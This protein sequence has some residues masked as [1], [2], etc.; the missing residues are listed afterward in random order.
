MAASAPKPAALQRLKDF[1]KRTFY[2]GRAVVSSPS[3]SDSPVA[4][5]P[6]ATFSALRALPSSMVG[7]TAGGMSDE[8]DPLRGAAIGGA[9]GLGHG[10]LN[11]ALMASA[12]R[13]RAEAAMTGGS[14][15]IPHEVAHM[16]SM[17]S[18][19]AAIGGA[20]GKDNEDRVKRAIAGAG[21]GGG[22]RAGRLL[23]KVLGPNYGM[24]LPLSVATIPLGG[25]GGYKLTEAL[26]GEYKKRQEKQL[27][28][29]AATQSAQV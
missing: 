15:R 16:L 4:I 3:Y 6:A 9:I 5:H 2:K 1:I 17:M 25:Y 24:S 29:T 7:A 22:A 13:A 11:P 27:A 21:I 19:G 12:R 20:T 8:T 14:E 18:T 28:A 26:G 23:A 10:V